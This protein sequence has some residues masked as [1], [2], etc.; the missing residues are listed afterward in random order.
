ME[1]PY[2]YHEDIKKG[3][4]LKVTLRNFERVCHGIV[5]IRGGLV[6]GGNTWGDHWKSLAET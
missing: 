6:C 3:V 2:V 1:T 5:N 4:T